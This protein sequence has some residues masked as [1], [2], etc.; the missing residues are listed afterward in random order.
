M[1]PRFEGRQSQSDPDRGLVGI[2]H[3]VV[4]DVAVVAHSDWFVMVLMD[5]VESVDWF[6]RKRRRKLLDGCDWLTAMKVVSRLTCAVLVN[7][8]WPVVHL[9]H[10][11]HLDVVAMAVVFPLPVDVCGEVLCHVVGEIICVLHLNAKS[12]NFINTD[13]NCKSNTGGGKKDASTHQVVHTVFPH[14]FMHV[15]VSIH[16]IS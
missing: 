1:Y 14:H 10:G 9:R 15:L 6:W 16:L 13:S 5:A 3:G 12:K 2:N 11:L 4:V 8:H 7:L